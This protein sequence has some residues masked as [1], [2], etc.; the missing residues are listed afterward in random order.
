MTQPTSSAPST[1]QPAP[2]RLIGLTPGVPYA[3]VVGEIETTAEGVVVRRWFRERIAPWSEIVAVDVEDG[4]EDMSVTRI[5][6]T[7]NALWR[8]RIVVVLRDGSRHPVWTS[9]SQYRGPD[10]RIHD[11]ARD[12]RGQWRKAVP[13]AEAA[14]EP[15]R[16][17]TGGDDYPRGLWDVPI[18][19]PDEDTERRGVPNALVSTVSVVLMVAGLVFVVAGVDSRLGGLLGL[20]IAGGALSRRPRVSTVMAPIPGQKC[21]PTSGSGGAGDLGDTLVGQAEKLGDVPVADAGGGEGADR[22]VPADPVCLGV[23]HCRA[24]LFD[25]AGKVPEADVPV[26][27]EP[28]GLQLEP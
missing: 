28:V 9:M 27:I 24:R 17:R 2:V 11:L 25:R 1:Y 26:D 19:L 3:G 22:L 14:P 12:L 10:P 4:R 13:D 21:R 15:D 23:S 6:T 8:G 18:W 16:R 5:F 7:A 20:L